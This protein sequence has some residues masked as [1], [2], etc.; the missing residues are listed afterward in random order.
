VCLFTDAANATSNGVYERLGYRPVV[1]MA[2]LVIE[3][4]PPN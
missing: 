4:Q 1:E 3:G 2:N